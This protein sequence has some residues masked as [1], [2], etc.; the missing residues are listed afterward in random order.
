MGKS[1]LRKEIF[2][3]R[4]VAETPG[5]YDGSKTRGARVH[6]FGKHRHKLRI[7][8]KAGVVG[9]LRRRKLP[10]AA[11]DY[12]VEATGSRHGLAEAVTMV[13]P[14]GTVALKSTVHGAVAIDMAP[15]IVNEVTLV[16]SRCGLFPPAIE[17]LAAGRV[18]VADM[19]SETFPLGE[20]EAA[21]RR[22][23]QK[24]VLKVLLCDNKP[25]S[26]G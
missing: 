14:R 1:L 5:C 20:A 9:E 13:R 16:G 2:C 8:E 17:L 26:R 10:V 19:I 3:K 25:I 12:V 24:G 4:T 21:F 18:H 23:Q 7:A 6:L 11:Y 15:V 22:A